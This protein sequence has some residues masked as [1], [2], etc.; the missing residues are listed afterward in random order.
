MGRETGNER[1][2]LDLRINNI[3]DG[4]QRKYLHDILFGVFDE[5]KKYSDG[6]FEELENRI[7]NEV[8]DDFRNYS[9]YTSA[10][11][12]GDL[13]KLSDF[14]Y[15]AVDFDEDSGERI[16]ESF[17]V[18]RI[19]ANCGYEVIKPYIG[20]TVAADITTDAG[21]YTDVN[22]R[23]GFSK[24][25]AD[26]IKRLYELFALNGK[27]W[28]TV[29][30]PFLFKFLDL[31]DENG[32]IPPGE[33]ITG[34]RLKSFGLG[35]Y[36]LNDMTL[37]WNVHG[38]TAKSGVVR[39]ENQDDDGISYFPA[40]NVVLYEHKIKIKYPRSKYLFYSANLKNFYSVANRDKENVISVISETPEPEDIFVCR[41]ADRND[42]AGGDALKSPFETQSNAKKMRR[43]DRLAE[44]GRRQVFTRGEIE[45]I[46]GLYTGISGSLRLADVYIDEKSEKRDQ[47]D[48]KAY[49]EDSPDFFDLNYFIEDRQIDG[50]RKRLVFRF[51]ALDRGDIFLYEKMWFLVSE[52]QLYFNEYKCIG[53]II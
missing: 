34:Y 28:V 42:G 24:I 48:Q 21:E 14:W 20:Q 8:P 7:K 32:T 2:F 47:T 49:G 40:E 53:K 39:Y 29:N 12:R 6:K 22:L 23:I 9:V 18:I 25:Y 26:R 46:C 4:D 11:A 36:I 35:K 5:Y 33:S 38:Y 41:I 3:T 50:S 17:A 13:N 15:E 43:T 30:C 27:P 1:D 52:L 45:R 44:S 51:D 19:F 16:T 10:A 37:V 31:T